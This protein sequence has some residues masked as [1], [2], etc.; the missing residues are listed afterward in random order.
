LLDPAIQASF[1]RRR[2][3][4]AMAD[5][6]VEGGYRAATITKVS[7]RA[8]VSRAT[9]YQHFENREQVLLATLDQALGELIARTETACEVARAGGGPRLE[10]GLDAVLT[11]VAERPAD[12]WVCFVESFCATPESVRR[13]LDAIARFTDLLAG[14]LP[15]EVSRPKAIEESLVG[16]VASLLSGRI[17]AG[18]ARL[19]PEMLPEI[20]TF[21][22]GPFLAT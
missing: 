19:V 22:R 1:K 10:A 16:G 18:Q 2:I 4:D 13:Y 8:E 5:L 12:A 7:H 3:A 9:I 20:T 6:C 15:A 21:V 14:A 11:W 17:R